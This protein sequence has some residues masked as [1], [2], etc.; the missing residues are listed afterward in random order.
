MLKIKKMTKTNGHG[1]K[2]RRS[3]ALFCSV[4]INKLRSNLP[5]MCFKKSYDRIFFFFFTVYC[6]FF[7]GIC[8]QNCCQYFPVN[9]TGYIFYSVAQT[10]LVTV[11]LQ[12][13]LESRNEC[14]LHR[15]HTGQLDP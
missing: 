12:D 5:D 2:F 4:Q 15:E 6:N 14:I 11:L 3:A 9:F 1:T 7:T 8:W 10:I 13:G